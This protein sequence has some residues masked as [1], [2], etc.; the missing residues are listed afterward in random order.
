MTEIIHQSNPQETQNYSLAIIKLS[1]ITP[2]FNY[3]QF[4]SYLDKFKRIIPIIAN[5]EPCKS[6][7]TELFGS[8]IN[9]LNFRNLDSIS[10]WLDICDIIIKNLTTEHTFSPEIIIN[11]HIFP[12]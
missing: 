12:L 3:E 9:L 7:Y 2:V 5:Y 6:F 10:K 8:I 11:I 4:N 1:K